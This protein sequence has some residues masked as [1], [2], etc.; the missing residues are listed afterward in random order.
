[1][2]VNF[3][4]SYD[5]LDDIWAAHPEG[6]R[7][8]DY[9]SVGG[10]DY[11]WNKYTLAW[12]P[13]PPE[14]SS[15]LRPIVENSQEGVVEYSDGYINYIGAFDTLAQAWEAFP[16]GGKEGDYILVAGEKLKWNKYT[17]NWGT[18]DPDASTPARPVASVYGDLHVHNDVV[19]GEDLIADIFKTY[20]TKV[21]LSKVTPQRVETEE[22]MEEMIES[23]NY[24][25]EQIY[26]V[27]EEE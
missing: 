1:M 20:A 15:A 18:A 8:G 13:T 9:I 11:S 22:I 5:T 4:G 23:G 6:G 12:E 19:V 27:P 25:K 14:E 2:N 16:E 7:E 21:E 10:E 24:D 26:Y 3:L 17:S